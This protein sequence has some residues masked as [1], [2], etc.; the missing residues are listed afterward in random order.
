M[1][2]RTV[3]A[4]PPG[5]LTSPAAQVIFATRLADPVGTIAPEDARDGP[6]E[7]GMLFQRLACGAV[8]CG[9]ALSR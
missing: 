2:V 1:G 7:P 6:V 3:S 5:R 8:G 4:C 9:G